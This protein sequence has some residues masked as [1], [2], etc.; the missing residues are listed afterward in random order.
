MGMPNGLQKHIV[1][2]WLGQELRSAR[3][4][5]LH[6]HRHITVSRDKDDWHVVAIDGDALL[7]LAAVK[8]RKR[9]V[10]YEAARNKHSRASEKHLCRLEC[11]GL[12]P[13]GADEQL[14]RSAHR[15][16]I[17]DNEHDWRGVRLG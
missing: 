14:E 16:V 9:N 10:E 11:L 17:V 4:H 2:E 13:L 6:R 12:P 1:V 8:G 7:Q 3:L 15:D 5:G